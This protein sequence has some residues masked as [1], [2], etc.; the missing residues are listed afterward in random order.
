M[1]A[2][3]AGKL[4]CERG[5][6]RCFLSRG[7]I[8]PVPGAL[9]DLKCSKVL[10]D[11]FLVP[12]IPSGENRHDALIATPLLCDLGG[13]PGDLAKIRDRLRKNVAQALHRVLVTIKGVIPQTREGL[14]QDR[15]SQ[16]V[17]DTLAGTGADQGSEAFRA[18]AFKDVRRARSTRSRGLFGR[19]DNLAEIVTRPEFAVSLKGKLPDKG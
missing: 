18:I 12:L 7:R 8:D 17:R 16:G 4:V 15:S 2:E 10:F 13:F 19:R 9:T 3:V 14:G 5:H 6:V 1:G 11:G